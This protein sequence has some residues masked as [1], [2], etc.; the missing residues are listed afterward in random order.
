MLGLAI[1]ALLFWLQFYFIWIGVHWVRWL[2]G[3]VERAL[4]IRPH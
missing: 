3:G 4:G 1:F 2:N